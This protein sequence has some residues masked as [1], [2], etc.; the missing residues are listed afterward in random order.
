L[1]TQGTF[2]P[3]LCLMVLRFQNINS[4]LIVIF[5][6]CVDWK[7]KLPDF[8]GYCITMEIWIYSFFLSKTSNFLE[9]KC[10]WISRRVIIQYPVKSG[11]LDFQSTQKMKMTIK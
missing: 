3:C 11:N 10:S 5:I 8:T 7:S 6:F 2:Q 9:H 1:T 4:Y